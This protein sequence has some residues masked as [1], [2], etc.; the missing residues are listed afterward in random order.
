MCDSLLRMTVFLL[1]AL[2]NVIRI[3]LGE[4][5]PEALKW[6]TAFTS[7]D[8]LDLYESFENKS[9]HGSESGDEDGRREYTKLVIGNT[10]VTK[11]IVH[12]TVTFPSVRTEIS[13]TGTGFI[14]A[15]KNGILYVLTAAHV[16][17]QFGENEGIYADRIWFNCLICMSIYAFTSTSVI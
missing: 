17:H 1:L 6:P 3:N 9:G 4:P 5:I 8:D 16:V 11:Q 7:A 15:D 2:V 10:D 14:I 13:Y 12:L